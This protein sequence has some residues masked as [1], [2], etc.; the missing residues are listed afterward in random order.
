MSNA[1]RSRRRVECKWLLDKNNS[2]K[3][4]EFYRLRHLT[5]N[6]LNQAE[7][8]YICKLV[9]DN[10][11]KTKLIFAI[12][13]NLLGRSQDHPLPP[14]FTDKELAKHFSKY[15]ISKIAN[16]RDTLTAKQSQLQPPPVLRQSIVPC[17]D[18]FRLLSDNEVS[19]IVRKSPTKTCKADPIPTTLLKDILPNIVPLLREIVNKPLQTGTFLDDLKVALV[20]PLLKKINLD[21]GEKNYRP[22]SNCQ[23][24][25]KL[26]ERAVN[27]QL[28]EHITTN[29][30]M[31][32]M[33]SAYIAGHITETALIKVK[34][35]I[36]NTINNKGVVCLVLLDL[37]AALD[38]V[39][40]QILLERLKNMFG[41]HEQ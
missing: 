5:T 34:A 6:I 14:G 25:G 19:V 29:N 1:I 15:F 32:P 37:L 40:H 21:L 7:K 41:L 35:D 22:V 12:C 24:I 38:T 2:D 28:N 39:D 23:Y 11:A 8:N 16:I 3:F 10:C 31:E 36:L 17:M 4:L 13:N 30:L 9:H 18:S 20:R 26:I 27:I 33:Q